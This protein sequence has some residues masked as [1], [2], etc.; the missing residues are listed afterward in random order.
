MD[1][2]Q[3]GT[4]NQINICEVS[5]LILTRLLENSVCD[6]SGMNGPILTK[7]DV[8]SFTVGTDVVFSSGN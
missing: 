4:M 8:C 6:S 2:R 5:A 3:K 1:G 7:V